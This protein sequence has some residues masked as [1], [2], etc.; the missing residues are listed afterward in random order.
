[1]KLTSTLSPIAALS[2]TTVAFAQSAGMGGMEM[3]DK[4]S[5]DCMD[6]KGMDPQKCK[7]MMKGMNSKQTTRNARPTAH[8]A[9]AV[10]KSA[11][12]AQGKVTLSHGPVKSL[13]WPAMTMGFVVKEKGL[14]DKLKVGKKVKV[15]FVQDGNAYVVTAIK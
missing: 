10:V 6:M 13:E 15:E 14:F 9:N 8:V 7:D 2:L 5:K 11:D 3:K 1:M 12:I 4:E